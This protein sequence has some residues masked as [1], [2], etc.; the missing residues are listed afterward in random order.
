MCRVAYPQDESADDSVADAPGATETVDTDNT[1]NETVESVPED[2][3]S[4]SLD[5]STSSIEIVREEEGRNLPDRFHWSGDARVGYIREEREDRDGT[6]ENLSA[7]QGRLRVGTRRNIFDW[8]VFDARLAINC[9]SEK[10][11]PDL[12]L[13]PSDTTTTSIEPGDISFDSLFFHVFRREGFDAA[14]GRMQTKFTTRAGV[15]A[16]S[17]DRNNSNSFNI[18]WTDGFHGA[19]HL[20]NESTWHFIAEY[21]DPEGAS[22]V[23][24]P[25]LDFTDDDTRVSYYTNWE[26]LQQAGPFTQ[27][28]IGVTYLPSAL[29]K[30]GLEGNQVEDYIGV[31]ARFATAWGWG[32]GGRRWNIAG[33]LGYA[34][35]TP[36]RAAVG[37]PGEGD[38]DGFAWA[39][40]LSLM[41]FR[42]NHSI[43][44]NYSVTDPG[45]LISPQYRANGELTE[46]RYLWRRTRDLALEF[47]VR[48]REEVEPLLGLSTQGE[49]DFFARFTIGLGR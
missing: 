20:N 36:T 41:D 34:P 45:W 29:Q 47:R 18:N 15:F 44:I 19:Y 23:R 37:L 40:Y 8:L 38:T 1:S 6:I 26:S 30:D 25:P 9:S 21:N 46:L 3:V 35:E 49:T 31:V 39:I 43:G 2:T 28:G 14:I 13:D 33:E 27:R 48:Y 42:P 17:L 11:D 5:D 16:K 7:W 24:R 12:T 32:D 22:N 4:G 10:C